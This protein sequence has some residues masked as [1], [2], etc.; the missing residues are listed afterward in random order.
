MYY[1]RQNTEAGVTFVMQLLC[2]YSLQYFS[3]TV[4][5][6]SDALYLPSSPS[7]RNFVG[8]CSGN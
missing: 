3:L 7:P 8:S 1:C 5:L 2:L 4:K 6:V